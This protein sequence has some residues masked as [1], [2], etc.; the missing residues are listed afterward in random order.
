ME[1][2]SGSNHKI[3][4]L[5]RRRDKSAISDIYMVGEEGVCIDS[6]WYTTNIQALYSQ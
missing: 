4:K 1:F 2:L 3:E 6:A 5:M